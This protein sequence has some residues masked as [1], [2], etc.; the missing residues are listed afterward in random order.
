[1]KYCKY[2]D[3][4]VQTKKQSWHFQQLPFRLHQLFFHWNREILPVPMLFGVLDCKSDR[5][6]R[7]TFDTVVAD[8]YVVCIGD[9]FTQ[10][11]F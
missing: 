2:K 7:H 10:H 6:F 8:R 3:T 11:C 5:V 4:W 9:F 1:M